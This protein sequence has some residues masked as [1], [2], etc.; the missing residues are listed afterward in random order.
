LNDVR[1][2]AR[3]LAPIL[4][5]AREMRTLDGL[6]SSAL[7]T[8][9]APLVSPALRA[10]AAGLPYDPQRVK[11]FEAL[12]ETLDRRAPTI[13]PALAADA[14]RRRLLPFYEAYFSNFIEGTEFPIDEAAG[15]VFDDVIPDGRPV[16]AHDVTGT[17]RLV[18]DPE[19]MQ[20]APRDPDDFLNL[21]RARHA[22]LLEARPDKLPGRFKDRDN[23]AGS[24]EFVANDVVEGTLRAGFDTGARVE[25][26]FARAAFMM[27]L[28]TEVHPFLDGNG[29]IARVMMNAELSAA[30]E[31]RIIIPTVYRNNYLLALKGATHNGHFDGLLAMLA[32]AQ[33]FTNRIDFTDRDRAEAQLTATNAFRDAVEADNAGVR[34]LLP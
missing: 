12:A 5:R 16:D 22:V 4:G 1:E 3:M 31:S 28:V 20:L 15:I 7:T 33:R 30:G 21:L 23:R 10:R 13:V 11:L 14:E 6:V 26:A 32:F 29:R 17:Y 18:A 9:D 2:Q 24:T 25:G 19:E 34:L 8:G 27:F